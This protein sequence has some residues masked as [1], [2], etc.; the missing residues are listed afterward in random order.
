MKVYFLE[1][2]RPLTKKFSRLD[3]GTIEKSS[4]PIVR[5]FTSHQTEVATL[6]DLHTQIQAHASLGHCLLKGQLA[7]PLTNESRA[8]TTS[9]LDPTQWLVL[10]FDNVEGIVSAESA[11][12]LILPE[13][14]DV[15]Y[16]LQYSASAGISGEAGLRAHV[17]YMLDQP[18]LPDTL[19]IWLTYLNLTNPI[20]AKNL[21]LSS[22][23]LTLKFALDRTVAQNDKLIYIA[24]PTLIGGIEDPLAGRRIQLIKRAR[25]VASLPESLNTW[26]PARVQTETQKLVERMRKEQGLKNRTPKYKLIGAEEIL[27]NPEPGMVTG[28][29]VDRQWVRINIAGESPGWAYYYD[30][31]NP[32]VLRN[33][34]GQPNVLMKDFLPDYFVE[35]TKR[36]NALRA[37]KAE[38]A[39]I[40][41]F[42]FRDMNT[43][44]F[45]NGTF[46]MRANQLIDCKPTRGDGRRL[47]YFFGQYGQQ[48]PAIIDDWA[49][50]FRP[51][52]DRLIC[53]SDKFLNRWVPTPLMLDPPQTDEVPPTIHRILMNV[54]G[55]DEEA[56]DHLINWLACA[57]QHRRKLLTS[58]VLHGVEGTGKGTLFS[59]I[60]MPIFGKEH[61]VEKPVSGFDDQFNA[62]LE[63]ALI[64]VID[65]SKADSARNP[66]AFMAKLKN[67][68]TEPHISIRA[69]RQNARM[70]P[71][72]TNV[73]LFSNNLDAIAIASTDRRFNVG[74]RQETTLLSV[75]E[76]HFGRK[77]KPE[78]FDYIEE[79]ETPMFAGFLRQY[80][81]DLGRAQRALENAPKARMR[82]ASMDALEQSLDAIKRGDL[83]FFVQFLED[84]MVNVDQPYTYQAYKAVVTDWIQKVGVKTVVTTKEVL[85]VYQYLFA[86]KQNPGPHKF[87]KM[88]AHKQIDMKQRHYDARDQ[89]ARRGMQTTWYLDEEIIA[90]FNKANVKPTIR[91]KAAPPAAA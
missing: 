58:W 69:M 36:A 26:T 84:G 78:D 59:R 25:D 4:Y 19:K 21:A 20:L 52:D 24:P 14:N 17:F 13:L 86:P 2:D 12:Q 31:E 16:I 42:V 63:L 73:I 6:D 61:C 40:R 45:Y 5:D 90:Q 65:E 30:A 44:T 10:D 39:E 76:N 79:V 67:F 54:V 1:A 89:V 8:S 72:Y 46:D 83:E 33:F 77:P 91:A 41:P 51:W 56:Y 82:I 74:E 66:A 88:L 57:Y 48:P 64:C 70:S 85:T 15:S 53:F 68:I 32:G 37:D 29:K 18:I 7:R 62:D 9:N 23:G 80:Q 49:Y 75:L 22:N 87:G 38:A 81:A 55:D 11:I 28:E 35:V 71:N 50:E 60:L 47:T 43:D 34:K 27:T 3:D